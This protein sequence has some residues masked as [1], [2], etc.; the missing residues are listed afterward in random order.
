[1][2]VTARQKLQQ[3]TPTLSLPKCQKRL[4]REPRLS[5]LLASRRSF[6]TCTVS[7]DTERF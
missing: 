1:M 6:F 2:L 5:A 7:R 3:D 4:V